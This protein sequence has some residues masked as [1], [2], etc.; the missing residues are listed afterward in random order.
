MFSAS[1]RPCHRSGGEV[2]ATLASPDVAGETKVLVVEDDE[3]TAEF[4]LDNLRADG[5]RAAAASGVG[6]G[7][8]RSRC[9][10]PTSCCST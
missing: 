1:A 8:A 5:Y 9:A 2:A 4:L 10:S 7:C 3:A 6:E